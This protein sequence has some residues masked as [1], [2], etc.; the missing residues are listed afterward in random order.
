MLLQITHVVCIDSRRDK[1]LSAPTP[2]PIQSWGQASTL[3]FALSIC[4]SLSLFLSLSSAVQCHES[5][6]N[7]NLEGRKHVQGPCTKCHKSGFVLASCARQSR[8]NLHEGTTP[9]TSH[10][11]NPMRTCA[12]YQPWH[13]L[14]RQ[15][16][17]ATVQ[18]H[19][20]HKQI[21]SLSHTHAHKHT[22]THTHTH[23]HQYIRTHTRNHIHIHTQTST[24]THMHTPR[25]RRSVI[26]AGILLV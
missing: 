24:H 11:H 10:A 4:Y 16:M 13:Q 12:W 21:L 8:W 15:H 6:M 1:N 14:L 18:I 22:H 23:T 25:S 2:A 9:Q 5:G 19:T 17:T 3:I 26:T 7:K 20:T